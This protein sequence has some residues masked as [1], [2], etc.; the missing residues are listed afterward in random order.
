MYP[1]HIFKIVAVLLLLST[2]CASCEGQSAPEETDA[3]ENTVD[4]ATETAVPE[5]TLNQ[6][7]DKLPEGLDFEEYEFRVM[8]Y[9][10]GNV[11][12]QWACYI[13]V[14]EANG[15]LMNDAAYNRN[16]LVEERLNVKL[17]CIESC[18]WGKVTDT[19]MA[20]ALADSDDYDY[21]VISSN[22]V[23]TPAVTQNAMYNILDLPYIDQSASYYFKK[24]SEVFKINDYQYFLAG[25]YTYP[26][27]SSVYCIFNKEKWN[28]WQL[29]DPYQLVYDGAW[30]YDQMMSLLKDTYQDLNG[31][32]KSDMEDFHGFTTAAVN[33]MLTYMYPAFG[34]VSVQFDDAGVHFPLY[35]D[36]NVEIIE[37][38]VSLK[39]N[40]DVY[41]CDSWDHFFNGNSLIC[42]Y[43]SS[44]ERLRHSEFD[45][46]LLPSPKF[47]ENQQDYI[48][49]MC[50]GMTAVPV[51]AANPERT[52]AIIEALFSASHQYITDAFIDNYVE[53]RVIRDEDSINMYRLIVETGIYD[54]TTYIDPSEK[55]LNYKLFIGL[56]SKDSTNLA[57]AWAEVESSVTAAY[58]EFYDSL[59]K[60]ES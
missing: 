6:Y 35:N 37:R 1:K 38:L 60:T 3:A 52:G 59:K 36:K 13:D 33:E 29:E 25:E 48:T 7:G 32:G 21:A 22:E 40:P 43:G 39:E 46:G 9:K 5:E 55:L 2:L 31:D 17:S 54:F 10:G 30:T 16:L 51:T 27:L 42:L 34:G 26:L 4:I 58:T 41:T 49:Y 11:D 20:S 24:A 12:D 28:E 50:G 53:Q 57:S 56:L 47:D 15:S 14:D 44:M 8:T 45:V 23:C 19:L 18:G